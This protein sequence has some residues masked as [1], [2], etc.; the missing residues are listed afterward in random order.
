VTA[1]PDAPRRVEIGGPRDHRLE[2]ADLAGPG[3][4]EARL[5]PLAIGI[6]GSDLH[7]LAGHHPFV[8]DPV[9]PGHELAAEVVAVGG[10]DD[11]AWVGARVALEPSLACGTCRHCRSGRY[12]ICESLRV[13]GFQAPGGMADALVAPLD[14]LHHLP[15]ALSHAAG[16][17]VEPVAVA[18]H[19]IRLAEEGM[20]TLDR[21]DVA[22]IGAGTIRILCA[23]VARAAGAEVTVADL[24]AAR[25]D[26][27]GGFGFAA[28][29]APVDRAFDDVFECVGT[30]G[31][32]RGAIDV[33]RKGAVVLVVGVYGSDPRIQAA[34][35]QDWELRLQGTLMYT[36]EDFEEAIRLLADGSIDAERMIT[37]EH[38]LDEVKRAF[39]VAAAGGRSLKVVLR[40]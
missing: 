32:L 5:R 8:S 17:L 34:L 35:I 31:A 38:P 39:E 30:E 24:D 33:S 16:A 25:R 29:E 23:Q 6:C 13:M 37:S 40:P 10:D 20:G 22:V 28:L 11:A 1:S 27:A 12:N 7:V 26:M 36:A 21:R 18:T 19:A 3:P 4:G 15:D 2:R 9:L 14:R